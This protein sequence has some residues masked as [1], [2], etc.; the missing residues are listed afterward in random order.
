M[1]MGPT[2]AFAAGLRRRSVNVSGERPELE[3]LGRAVYG[4]V[5][6]GTRTGDEAA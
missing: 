1:P 6:F 2:V 4:D 3:G 5:A